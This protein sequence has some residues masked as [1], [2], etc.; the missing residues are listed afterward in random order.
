MA[1]GTIELGGNIRLTGFGDID[2]GS[3]I[4]VKKVVGSF[5]KKI[6][7]KNQK[8]QSFTLTLKKVHGTV[9]SESSGKFELQA[10]LVADKNYNSDV[11]HLNLMFA[12]DKA[13]KKIE[14]GM[15]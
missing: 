8:F 3:M 13:L 10:N 7:E 14:S 6:S 15:G 12:V 4:I 1:K 2:G 5:V 11:T 9:E